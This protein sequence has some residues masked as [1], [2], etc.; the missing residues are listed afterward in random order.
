MLNTID[1]FIK[2]NRYS[3]FN[4]AAIK[5][6][7]PLATL[8]RRIK[9]LE[10]NLGLAL[11][12]RERGCLRLTEPGKQFYAQCVLPVESLQNI[13]YEFQG[14]CDT[15]AGL[16]KLIAP[17]NFM[18]NKFVNGLFENFYQRFPEINIQMVLSDGC[19]DLKE[20][21]FDLAVRIGKLMNSQN[22]C[23]VIGQMDFVL[24]AAP[25][26]IEQYGAPK[27][28]SDLAKLPHITFTHFIGWTFLAAD[29]QQ[30]IFNPEPSFIANDIDMCALAA[31]AGRGVYYGPRL[32]LNEHIMEGKLV[33]LLTDFTPCKRNINLVWPD[34]LIPQRT[35]IL[36]DY[37]SM[38]FSEPKL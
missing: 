19:V 34:K 16:I 20:T 24:A 33:T 12:Y 3:T 21:E 7:I 27:N 32:Y 17:Q 18:K 37:L 30:S 2:T 1:L 5:L 10:S 22:I 9:K 8:Q 38:A 15:K 11:F 29:G 36:I 35:R 4:E 28:F 25:E 14:P 26:L 13:L 31:V 23:K 6:N